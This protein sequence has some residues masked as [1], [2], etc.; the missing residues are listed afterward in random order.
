MWKVRNNN[1]IEYWISDT[2]RAI[3]IYKN[4]LVIGPKS[5]LVG[6]IQ[7]FCHC[8]LLFGDDIDILKLQCLVKAKS[9]GWPIEKIY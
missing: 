4:D 5:K 9:V 1:D 6:E 8:H 7:G 3:K 2:E